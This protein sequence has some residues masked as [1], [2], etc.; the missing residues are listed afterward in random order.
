MPLNYLDFDYSEDA[1]G[2]GTFDAM[3]SVAPAQW[4]ALQTEVAQVLAWAH[5]QFPEACG[6]LDEGAL[7]HYDLQGTQEVATPLAI[8]FDPLTGALRSSLGVAAPPR[9]SLSLSI[10]GSAAFCSALRE[11]FGID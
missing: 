3:A 1:D 9:T 11:R 7:W 2:T 10:T 4:Q 5:G 6:P 8:E